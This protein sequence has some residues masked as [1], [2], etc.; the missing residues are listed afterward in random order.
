MSVEKQ[1]GLA[2]VEGSNQEFV[3]HIRAYAREFAREYDTVTVDNLRRYALGRGIEPDHKNAWGAIFMGREWECVGYEP[4][5]IPTNRGR[6]IRRW[7][8]RA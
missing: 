6:V 5:T 7:R 2:L 1:L 8:L 4:S 3:E